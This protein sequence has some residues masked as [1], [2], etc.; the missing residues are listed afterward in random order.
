MLIFCIACSIHQNDDFRT[1]TLD[2]LLLLIF[3][4]LFQHHLHEMHLHLTPIP[5]DWLDDIS[6]HCMTKHTQTAKYAV[7]GKITKGSRPSITVNNVMCQCA[8]Y[9]VLKSIILYWTISFDATTFI[10]YI[11]VF[12]STV[13]PLYSHIFLFYSFGCCIH[14]IVSASCTALNIYSFD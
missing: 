10:I 1:W 2:W 12:T 8:Q 11:C 4:T 14:Q 7:Q 5:H 6:L 3:C 13:S 9:H